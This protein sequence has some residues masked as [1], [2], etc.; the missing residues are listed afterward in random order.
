MGTE[1]GWVARRGEGPEPSWLGLPQRAL[2]WGSRGGGRHQPSSHL[3]AFPRRHPSCHARSARHHVRSAS[4]PEH[5]GGGCRDGCAGRCAEPAVYLSRDY[6]LGNPQ[7]YAAFV[8]C[9]A[10]FDECFPLQGGAVPATGVQG[11][12]CRSSWQATTLE[13]KAD[14]RLPTALRIIQFI[15]SE[16]SAPAVKALPSWSQNRPPVAHP[17]Q[18]PQAGGWEACARG[19][20]LVAAGHGPVAFR[21]IC[22]PLNREFWVKTKCQGGNRDQ[23]DF[24]GARG[25]TGKRAPICRDGHEQRPGQHPGNVASSHQGRLP[26]SR[27]R[28]P[29]TLQA[30]AECC[31]A[32]SSCSLLG[33]SHSLL[34]ASCSLAVLRQR[35]SPYLSS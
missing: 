10:A 26:P 4:R 13:S 25:T 3:A 24:F 21:G 14:L 33:G 12:C 35:S 1:P 19:P 32:A 7:F 20:A 18:H 5:R 16:A 2:P 28:T 9:H 8:N 27:G 29:P 6:A 30:G 23:V 15:V 31:P 11:V 34:E 17:G 22:S